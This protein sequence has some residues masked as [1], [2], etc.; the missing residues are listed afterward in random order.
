MWYMREICLQILCCGVWSITATE[1]TKQ[2]W[3]GIDILCK[4]IRAQ[5]TSN[6]E[7]HYNTWWLQVKTPKLNLACCTY[8]RCQTSQLDIP[9]FSTFQLGI[10]CDQK[11]QLSSAHAGLSSHLVIEQALMR[12]LKTHMRAWNDWNQHLLWLLCQ[13]LPVHK[14]ICQCRNLLGLT[15]ILGKIIGYKTSTWLERHIN[16]T[17]RNKTH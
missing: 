11:K 10:I 12:S 2:E 14:L 8:S 4:F 7:L 13:H 15:T 5:Y 9:K 16:C 1:V 6:W 3:S 17:R